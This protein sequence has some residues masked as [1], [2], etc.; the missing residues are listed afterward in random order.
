MAKEKGKGYSESIKKRADIFKVAEEVASIDDH[1]ERMTAT[2]ETWESFDDAE[3]KIGAEHEKYVHEL[4]DP[5][6]E[7]S[8]RLHDI[9]MA[10]S[11]KAGESKKG[12]LPASSVDQFVAEVAGEIMPHMFHYTPGR[13][14]EKVHPDAAIHAVES[15]KYYLSIY[16]QLNK[17]ESDIYKEIKKDFAEGRPTEGTDKMVRAIIVAK[18][19]LEKKRLEDALVP[20]ESDDDQKG[21]KHY[22]FMMKTAEKIKDDVEAQVGKGKVSV[23]KIAKDRATFIHMYKL[24]SKHLYGAIAESAKSPAKDNPE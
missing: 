13:E 4:R 10:V 15:V 18:Q 23:A 21:G 22:E 7:K 16:D 19:A 3:R 14:G 24:Y 8:K 9:Y 20:L 6:S 11:K 12:V 5:K 1:V 17:G 2:A